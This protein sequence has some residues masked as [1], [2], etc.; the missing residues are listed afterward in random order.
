MAAIKRVTPN[1]HLNDGEVNR[2]LAQLSPDNPGLR[3]EIDE[4]NGLLCDPLCAMLAAVDTCVCGR[5]R[6]RGMAMI[7]FQRKPSGWLA[8]IHDVVVDESF[9]RR[10]VGEGLVR[11]LMEVALEFSQT[12]NAKVTLTLTS[13]PSR[14]AANPLY[15][16]LGF[17]LVAKAE[18]E[19]GTN[20]YK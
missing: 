16:K 12:R 14:G 10:G 19:S 2:L 8:E 7:F 9:R 20:L 1:V 3:I 17:V 11:E 5:E 13:K 18:G 4:L 15:L 6:W